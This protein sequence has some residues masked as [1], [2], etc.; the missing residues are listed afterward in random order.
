MQ[1]SSPPGDTIQRAATSI[2]ARTQLWHISRGWRRDNRWYAAAW[3]LMAYLSRERGDI[4]TGR[5]RTSLSSRAVKLSRERWFFPD[6]QSR[7][8]NRA[9]AG[10]IS[11]C[12]RRIVA[13]LVCRRR[14]AADYDPVREREGRGR[15]IGT[16]RIKRREEEERD[17]FGLPLVCFAKRLRSYLC[18]F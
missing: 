8:I 1:A 6:R 12:A 9:G 3:W 13:R 10:W 15:F 14:R 4:A 5:A 18:I 16:R 2:P 7:C 11:Q 17:L